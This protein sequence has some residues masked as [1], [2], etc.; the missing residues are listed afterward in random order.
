MFPKLQQTACWI[1]AYCFKL[2]H[3]NCRRGGGQLYPFFCSET[4]SL[5]TYLPRLRAITAADKTWRFL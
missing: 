2:S 3:L 5:L 1:V 4:A